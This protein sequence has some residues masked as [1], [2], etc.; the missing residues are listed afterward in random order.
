MSKKGEKKKNFLLEEKLRL[1]K[2][3]KI[4]NQELKKKRD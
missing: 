4:L 1:F 2:T 3:E